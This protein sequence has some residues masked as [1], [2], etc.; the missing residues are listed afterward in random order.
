MIIRELER[1]GNADFGRVAVAVVDKRPSTE[2]RSG[3]QVPVRLTVKVGL[4]GVGRWRAGDNVP[5]AKISIPWS[6]AMI[7]EQVD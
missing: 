5:L 2:A 7:M 1:E 3:V 4:W 6:Y